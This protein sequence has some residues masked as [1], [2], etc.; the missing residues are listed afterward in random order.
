MWDFSLKTYLVMPAESRT[1]SCATLMA[2][3]SHL[4]THCGGEQESNMDLEAMIAVV[5]HKYMCF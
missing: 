4:A 5:W 1:W 3:V 2:G